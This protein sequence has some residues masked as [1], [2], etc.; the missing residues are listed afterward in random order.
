MVKEEGSRFDLAHKSAKITSS[1]GGQMSIYSI[2]E[3]E[4]VGV[5][6]ARSRA[7]RVFRGGIR[8]ICASRGAYRQLTAQQGGMRWGVGGLGG[9]LEEGM[10][11]SHERRR[12]EECWR[13]RGGIGHSCFLIEPPHHTTSMC[14]CMSL[15]SNFPADGSEALNTLV[16][17][18]PSY[19]NPPH[20]LCFG[21]VTDKPLHQSRPPTAARPHESQSQVST[22]A[23]T[24][25]LLPYLCL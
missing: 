25:C 4:A 12:G 16:W 15:L 9:L 22:Q 11:V 3:R 20:G 7:L 24:A 21:R 5:L 6:R 19:R 13:A 14:V 8:S 1:S 17:Q 2:F 18:Q 23:K 10:G